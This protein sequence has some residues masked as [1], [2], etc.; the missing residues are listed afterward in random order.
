MVLGLPPAF[1]GVDPTYT[2][3]LAARRGFRGWQRVAGWQD[4]QWAQ[5]RS[6][7]QIPHGFD[8]SRAGPVRMHDLRLHAQT[9]EMQPDA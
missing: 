9:P 8:A 4:R 3:T 6:T 7:T 5:A 2:L 1:A